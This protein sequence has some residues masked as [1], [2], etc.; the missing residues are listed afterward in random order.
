[1]LAQCLYTPDVDSNWQGYLA[2]QWMAITIAVLVKFIV[3]NF[4]SIQSY[5]VILLF[6]ILHFTN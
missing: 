4:Q 1:M 2:G 3:F 6:C 5:Y